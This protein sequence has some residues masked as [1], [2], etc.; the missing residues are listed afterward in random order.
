VSAV[1]RY[2]VN[3]E[4]GEHGCSL[5]LINNYVCPLFVYEIE[6][7]GKCPSRENMRDG[8]A[9]GGGG[10]KIIKRVKCLSKKAPKLAMPKLG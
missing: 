7:R 6:T 1:T 5:V 9:K 3:Q 4:V 10:A 2:A 8:F